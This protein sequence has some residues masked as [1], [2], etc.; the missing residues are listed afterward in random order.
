[1]TPKRK[2]PYHLPPRAG[3]SSRPAEDLAHSQQ[4]QAHLL[5]E[6]QAL[7][8]KLQIQRDRLAATVQTLQ[9]DLNQSRSLA[10]ESTVAEQRERRQVAQVCREELQQLLVAI[11]FKAQVLAEA[12]NVAADP[13]WHDL[14]NLIDQAIQHS[15]K[16]GGTLAPHVL[17]HEELIPALHWLVAWM[18]DR[19]GLV[20]A[21]A[22][23]PSL[24]IAPEP[25][26]LL[27]FHAI[28][29]LLVN[30]AHHAQVQTA[31]VELIEQ[32]GCMR[33]TV[34]D[35]GIGFDPAALTGRSGNGRIGLASI[36]QMLDYLG[37]KLD[38]VS[39]PGQGSRFTLTVP[40]P[41]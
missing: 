14:R 7:A 17:Q 5:L 13:R 29:H 23:P 37:G 2:A 25:V 41:N 27:L 6:T 10:V 8:R 26:A 33:V 34:S 30:V 12:L 40:L 9:Q 28:R 24:A 19:F 18:R 20:V 22:V 1:M 39:A 32:D 16:I 15:S 31:H 36:Q 35:H 3:H 11:K 38:I 21:L 4:A